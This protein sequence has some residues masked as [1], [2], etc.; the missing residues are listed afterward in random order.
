M[1]GTAARSAIAKVSFAGLPEELNRRW[2]AAGWVLEDSAVVDAYHLVLV[3][4]VDHGSP[5]VRRSVLKRLT[6]HSDVEKHV[7]WRTESLKLVT[8]RHYWER[9]RGFEGTWDPMEG[10]GRVKSTLEEMGRRHGVRDMLRGAR[11]VATTTTYRTADTS[12]VY[13]ASVPGANVSRHGHRTVASGI[14]DM[15]GFA[16]LLGAEFAWRCD[17]GRHAAVTGLDRL[18]TAAAV[19]HSGLESIVHVHHGLVVYGDNT[20][21]VLFARV[22]E[23][24]R[25]LV[26][27]FFKGQDFEYQNE[28]RFVVSVL[29]GRPVEDEFY[30]R[31]APDLRSVF[32]RAS[33]D[34]SPPP[35]ACAVLRHG[36]VNERVPVAGGDRGEPG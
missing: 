4:A 15:P 24:A 18:V 20:G 11:L 14:R 28:Y 29:G 30:P 10:R 23:Y 7:P 12:L 5:M 2:P 35:R 3:F 19:G 27:H 34:V 8:L 9:H 33:S 22:S 21:G 6:K 16:Q 36:E 17:A 26:A 31:I 13:S 25:A 32:E 1:S